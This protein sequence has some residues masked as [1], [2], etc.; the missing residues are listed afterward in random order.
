M[1]PKKRLP[2][3]YHLDQSQKPYGKCQ[4]C[5]QPREASPQLLSLPFFA[6]KLYVVSLVGPWAYDEPRRGRC[7][8]RDP[9]AVPVDPLLSLSYVLAIHV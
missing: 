9:P 8:P 7:F 6:Q 4:G 2:K 1:P 5:G 3:G